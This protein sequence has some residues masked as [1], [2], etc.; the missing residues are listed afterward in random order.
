V[1]T[2]A[3]DVIPLYR[4]IVIAYDGNTGGEAALQQGAALARLSKAELHLLGVV[5]SSG[6]LLLDPAIVPLELLETERSV[7][8]AAMMDCVHDLG[9]QGIAAVTAIRDGEPA[10][11]IIAYIDEVKADCVVV[12]HSHKGMLAHWFEGS[13]GTRLL[14]ALP[15]SLLVASAHNAT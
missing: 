8:L 7:L 11:E 5:V 12:G 14:D 4:K 9:Q 6:G 2:L 3:R 15:C 1:T 13:V 10:R